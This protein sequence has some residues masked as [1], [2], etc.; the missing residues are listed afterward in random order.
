M[1]PPLSPVKV[2]FKWTASAQLLSQGTV[3]LKILQE[4]P[5]KLWIMGKRLSFMRG[6]PKIGL[7][8]L[9]PGHIDSIEIF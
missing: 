9:P 1:K 6:F 4:F 7:W 5:R 3:K 2:A 8:T